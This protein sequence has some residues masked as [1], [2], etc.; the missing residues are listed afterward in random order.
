MA[1]LNPTP[2][3]EAVG[4]SPATTLS[5]T[6]S[7]SSDHYK[8]YFGTDSTKVT[9]GHSEAYRGIVYE[10]E[11]DPRVS[12]TPDTD[13]YWRIEAYLDGED[14]VELGTV[15]FNV[16]ALGASVPDAKKWKRRLWSLADN[17]F[18]YEDDSTPPNMVSLGNLEVDSDGGI[19]TTHAISAV[20]AYGKVFIVNGTIKKVVDFRSTKLT[21]AGLTTPPEPGEEITQ[22]NTGASMIVDFVNTAKTEVYGFTTTATPFNDSDTITTT[23]TDFVPATVT[24]PTTPHF[25]DWTPYATVGD[26]SYGTMPAAPT[27]AWLYRGRIGLAGTPD[28]PHVWFYPRQGNPHDWAYG[29][30]DEQSAIAGND[31]DVGLIGD[32]LVQAIPYG[33]DYCLYA[34]IDELWL[35]RGDPAAGGSLEQIG[36][37]VGLIDRRARCRD[38][39]GNLY[40]MDAKGVYKIPAG[41]GHP[42]P[43]TEDTI[44]DMA[45]ELGLNPETQVITM[46]YSARRHGIM[47][48]VTEL[49]NGSNQCYWLSLKTGGFFPC[50]F[51]DALGIHYQHYYNSDEPEFRRLLFG[52]ADGHIRRLDDAAKDDVT[53]DDTKTAISSHVTIGPMQIAPDDMQGKLNQLTVVTAGG[54]SGGSQAD[55]DGVTA[56]VYVAE[57]AEEIIEKVTAAS[58]P[59][60]SFTLTGPGRGRPNRCRARGAFAAVRLK[61]TTLGQTWAMERVTAAVQRAGRLR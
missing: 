6:D 28:H 7:V 32:I 29:G 35:Q 58:S 52:C 25:Y 48:S 12:L 22:A 31:A 41:M 19:D 16:V 5:W 40:I 33:D 39:A 24:E 45:E 27:I 10:T 37:N 60:T 36:F 30:D 57:T 15:E 34:C 8:V 50:S 47:I 2:A 1:L 21:H 59:F 13:Y 61:N 54:A 49:I 53:D 4:Q 44:P 55:S 38:R 14:M 11:Y 26:T 20:A 43:L 42:E 9:N 23:G 3:D 51:P 56:E 18:W 46:G 17:K